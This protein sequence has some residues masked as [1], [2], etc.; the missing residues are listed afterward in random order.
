M[1]TEK[2][3]GKFFFCLPHR[4]IDRN[5][6]LI[7]SI[8]SITM[9]FSQAFL[10]CSNVELGGKLG[11]E[12]FL[13]IEDRLFVHALQCSSFTSEEYVYSLI[14]KCYS[15]KSAY[16]TGYRICYTETKVLETLQH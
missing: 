12:L 10:F 2:I 13:A 15:P 14:P 1:V 3:L 7:L 8:S 16:S 4:T 6:G 5:E 11:R 9:V